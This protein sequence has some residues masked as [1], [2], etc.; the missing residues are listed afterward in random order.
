[1]RL[2]PTRNAGGAGIDA[3][4]RGWTTA[5]WLY[6]GVDAALLLGST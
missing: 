6:L 2:G 1:M 4:S 5:L 3:S